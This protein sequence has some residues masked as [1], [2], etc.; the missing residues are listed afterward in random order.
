MSKSGYVCCK[1]RDCFMTAVAADQ[2]KGAMCGDC[3]E[4]GCQDDRECLADGAYGGEALQD[5][6]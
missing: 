1:C 3:V 4:A 6:A 5:A 2:S